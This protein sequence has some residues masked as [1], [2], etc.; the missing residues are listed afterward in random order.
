MENKVNM[1][2]LVSILLTGFGYAQNNFDLV[3]NFDY[4]SNSFLNGIDT[5]TE[6]LGQYGVLNKTFAFNYSLGSISIE[7]ESNSPITFSKEYSYT[8]IHG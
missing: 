7:L 1:I 4:S 5:V 8:N 2:F 3:E 6:N